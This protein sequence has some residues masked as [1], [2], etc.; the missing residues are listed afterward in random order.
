MAFWRR[1]QSCHASVS[2]PFWRR[3]ETQRNHSLGGR[4]DTVDVFILAAAH[5]LSFRP[6]QGRWVTHLGWEAS[7]EAAMRALVG[8]CP[9][10]NSLWLG[11]S[12][13]LWSHAAN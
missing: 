8:C 10:S 1:A 11:Y 6:G 5:H 13:T 12:V 9:V 7:V 4:A 2:R 3:I